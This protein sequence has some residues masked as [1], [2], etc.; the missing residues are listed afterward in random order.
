MS[1]INIDGFLQAVPELKSDSHLVVL[2]GSPEGIKDPSKKLTKYAGVQKIRRGLFIIS[3]YSTI[4][5]TEIQTL[6][7]ISFIKSREIPS[8]RTKTDD[9]YFTRAFSI[10]A[11]SLQ[12]PTAKQ[13]KRIERLVKKSVGIRLRPGVIL[14]PLLKS[15]EQKRM[16]V[17][18]DKKPLIDSIRFKQLMSEMGANTF[19]WS[20]LRLVNPESSSLISKSIE[21]NLTKDLQAVETKIRNLRDLIQDTEISIQKLK[22]NYSV[23]SG[24]FKETKTKWLLAR[25]L[26]SFD[27]E[28]PLKRTYNLLIGTRRAIIERESSV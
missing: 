12:N 13:K 6:E 10:V 28:K 17:S 26:W 9:I 3:G 15:K 24:R 25:K 1:E 11:F 5:A 23:L 2:L 4:H 19:R 8:I 16:S 7:R 27:A 20:R 22:R 14:F 18:D 21:Q